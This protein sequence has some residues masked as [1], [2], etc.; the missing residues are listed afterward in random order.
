MSFGTAK[1]R[2]RCGCG[3]ISCR[4]FTVRYGYCAVGLRCCYGKLLV[5]L[6]CVY[7]V[8]VVR[9]V[10][11]LV[12]ERVRYYSST[13]RQ[14]CR[15]CAVSLRYD[16]SVLSVQFRCIYGAFTL[17]LWCGCTTIS[18]G[19]CTVRYRA[20]AWCCTWYYASCIVA[21]LTRMRPRRDETG[22]GRTVTGRSA[23]LVQQPGY[24]CLHSR[25]R[26][27]CSQALR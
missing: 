25:Y 11:R 7:G 23:L 26:K 10:V 3:T 16:Y 19:T 2:L 8:V 9:L 18:Y 4:K 14:L 12:T 15:N 24:L 6:S 20:S 17:L 5:P 27:L 13:V 21:A 22:R 1:L